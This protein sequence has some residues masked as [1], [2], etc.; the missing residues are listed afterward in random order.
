MTH[1]AVWFRCSVPLYLGMPDEAFEHVLE[2]FKHKKG[3][4][5]DTDLKL[6][7]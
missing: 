7:I 6:K 1:I 5:A 2:D 4:T 3:V